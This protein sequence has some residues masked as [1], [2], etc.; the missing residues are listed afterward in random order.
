MHGIGNDFVVLDLRDGAPAPTPALAR[1]LADRHRGVGFDQLVTLSPAE[2]GSGADAVVGFL[3]ADGSPSGA[4]GN[5]AR[6]AA[7]LLMEESGRDSVALR[8]EAGLLTARRASDGLITVDMGPPRLGWRE[9]P[10]AFEADVDAPPLSTPHPATAVSALSMGNPHCVLFVADAEAAPL[11]TLGP[12]LERDRLFPER[13]NVEFAQV[14]DRG[15][16]RARVWERGAGV[17]LA[18]GSGA[19]AVG[20]AAMR[21]GLVDRRVAVRLDG[22]T[23]TIEWPETPGA[24]VLMT[25]PAATVFD[26]ELSAGFLAGVEAA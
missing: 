26:G 19:C 6:C 24:G 25:G 17:T 12:A 21:R 4:C 22:G 15:A 7:L 9:V 13:A 11:E 1:A 5:G 3:N 20:V 10:L 23:L 18:C 16:V 8:T 2:A 14:I